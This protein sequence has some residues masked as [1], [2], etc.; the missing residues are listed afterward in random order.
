MPPTTI[1]L[2]HPLLPSTPPYPGD[3]AYACTPRLTHAAHGCSVQALAL[4]THTGTHIDAPAHFVAGGRTIDTYPLHELS[5]R[6]VVADVS[7]RFPRGEISEADLAPALSKFREG[8]G[9]ERPKVLLLRTGA[10]PHWTKG[11]Y[12]DSPHLSRGAAHAIV[13]AG[14]RIVGVD[15]FSPDAVPP[16][17]GSNYVVEESGYPAHE[18]LLGAGVLIAENLTGLEGLG[19]GEG[20]VVSLVPMKVGGGDGAPIRAFATRKST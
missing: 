16:A 18:V 14:V 12:N 1:D 15:A 13:R 9:E 17:D 19:D 2:T 11:A 8:E 10:A 20:W 3:P 7:A 6:C 4:G 5:G